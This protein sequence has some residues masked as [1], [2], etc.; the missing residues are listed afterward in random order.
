MA[1]FSNILG[2]SFPP[3]NAKV[4]VHG[5]GPTLSPNPTVLPTPT[6]AQCEIWDEKL[7]EGLRNPHYKKKDLD[8]RRSK[9]KC[10]IYD[11]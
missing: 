10:S 9:V 3:H 4:H 7:R 2:D 8:S 11:R 6:L 5:D 1:A